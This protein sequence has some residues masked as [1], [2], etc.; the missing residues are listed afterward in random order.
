MQYK[1]EGDFITYITAQ[2]CEAFAETEK[3]SIIANFSTKI[4]FLIGTS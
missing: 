4:S 3:N 2:L 1:I